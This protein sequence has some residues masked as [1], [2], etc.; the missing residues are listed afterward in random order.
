MQ[1][2]RLASLYPSPVL[3]EAP[4]PTVAIGPITAI[5]RKQAHALVVPDD[6][7]PVAVML[8]PAALPIGNKW[9]LSAFSICSDEAP[10]SDLAMQRPRVR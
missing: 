3:L 10:G 6:Q 1:R 7:H 9:Q 2:I 5:A 4:Q 8:T